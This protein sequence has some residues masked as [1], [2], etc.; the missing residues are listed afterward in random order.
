[1]GLR[2]VDGDGEPF[3]QAEVDAG[4]DSVTLSLHDVTPEQLVVL[5]RELKDAQ[6]RAAAGLVSEPSNFF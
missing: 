1:M 3:L 4:R 6:R 2:I 5:A